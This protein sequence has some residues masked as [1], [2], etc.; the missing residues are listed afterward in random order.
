[1]RNEWAHLFEALTETLKDPLHVA[2][3]LHGDHPSVVLLIN[4]HQ[5]CLLIVMP[6]KEPYY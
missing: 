2:P 3:F 4:P 5:E 1:M 6:V